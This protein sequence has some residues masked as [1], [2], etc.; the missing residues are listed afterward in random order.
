MYDNFQGKRYC[1][2]GI[3]KLLRPEVRNEMWSMLDDYV[4]KD[5]VNEGV[6]TFILNRHGK[7]VVCLEIVLH[8][9]NSLD[10]ISKI[11]EG[12]IAL[13]DL[14]VLVVDEKDHVIMLLPEE[15]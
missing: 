9:Q 12:D 4:N 6:Q 3:R 13:V 11:I 2:S 15:L 1:S 5:L 14:K 7:G 8:P 10:K